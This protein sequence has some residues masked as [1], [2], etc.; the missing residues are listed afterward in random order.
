M[1]TPWYDRNPRKTRQQKSL[2]VGIF[3]VFVSIAILPFILLYSFFKDRKYAP[4]EIFILVGVL[5]L[6]SLLRGEFPPQDRL[7]IFLVGTMLTLGG[8]MWLWYEKKQQ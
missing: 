8:S 5:S 3:A 1:P 7:G 6:L 2:V 4:Q